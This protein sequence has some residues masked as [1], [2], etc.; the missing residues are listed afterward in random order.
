MTSYE[1]FKEIADLVEKL[2]EGYIRCQIIVHETKPNES[3]I[4]LMIQE[5]G[6]K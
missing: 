3:R 2:G 6:S 5:P 4:R 1:Q